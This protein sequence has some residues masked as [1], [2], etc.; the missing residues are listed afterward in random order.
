MDLESSSSKIKTT[1]LPLLVVIL[2]WGVFILPSSF[3]PYWSYLDDPTTLLKGKL[4]AANI[5]IL[6]PGAIS[7]RYFPAYWLYY[8]LLFKFCGFSLY[9]YYI[10]QSLMFLLTMFLVYSII[11]KV[12]KSTLSGIFAAFLVVTGSPVA[13]NAYT[14]GKAEPKI[15]FYLLCTVYIFMALI[16]K[17]TYRGK[18]FKVMS[19]ISI[20]LLIFTAVLTKE[21][22]AVFIVFAFTATGIAFLFH[23]KYDTIDNQGVKPYLLLLISTACSIALARG[24]FFALTPSN[25]SNIYTTYQI[26]LALIL[27]NLKFYVSQQPDV[28][29]LG[30]ITAISVGV[31]YKQ[32]N[33]LSVKSFVF[34]SAMF[35][36]GLAYILGH[37]I[38]KWALGYYFLVPSS[39]FSIA[40]V[41][42][43]CS[44]GRSLRSKKIMYVSIALILITRVYSIPYFSYI[45]HAQKAQDKIYTEAIKNYVQRAGPD[46]RLLVE[47]WPLLVEPVIQ[48]NILIKRIFGKEELQ[49][50]GIKDIVSNMTISQ[51]TLKRYNFTRVPDKSIRLPRKND[52]ILTFTGNRQSA[53]RLRG[54]SPFVNKKGSLCKRRGMELVKVATNEVNWKGFEISPFL[55]KMPTKHKYSAGY[56]LYKVKNPLPKFWWEGRW[57]DN[58]ISSKA[59]FSFLY[60]NQTTVFVF[61]G[62]VTKH[63]VPSFLTITQD[64]NIIKKVLLDK[65][66]P[67]SFTLEVSSPKS[68]SLVDIEVDAAKTFNP[69]ILGLTNDD[70]NLSVQLQVQRREGS[71][72]VPPT[73]PVVQKLLRN[74]GD[75]P[76]PYNF[77]VFQSNFGMFF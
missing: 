35:F 18:V 45:A 50:E 74:R 23:K 77:E 34:G 8:A 63:T 3:Y 16:D 73:D 12:T 49:L 37:L 56:I 48:S 6:R 4:L 40:I 52:Y 31:L 30:L 25:A 38:W 44:L 64:N 46:E 2:M 42:T 27:N 66:G 29:L 47:E 26:N 14:F 10:M 75:A 1:I 15:L 58:W 22:A 55:N 61:T 65:A 20:T 51:D 39:L 60:R 72:V 21:T 59:K 62:F 32:G 11:I 7:G 19:W 33:Q 53:R 57:S 69:K 70:R 68:N 5:E 17:G 36:T 41:V 71:E 54:V 24:L 28:L 13:E 43:L 67:F 76:V 9:G